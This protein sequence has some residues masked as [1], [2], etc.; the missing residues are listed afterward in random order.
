MVQV[1]EQAKDFNALL[2]ESKTDIEI[3]QDIEKD[4]NA[5]NQS[6]TSE[7]KQSKDNSSNQQ[8]FDVTFSAEDKN[9][10]TVN[11]AQQQNRENTKLIMQNQKRQDRTSLT[12]LIERNDSSEEG[13]TQKSQFKAKTQ[14]LNRNLFESEI[15]VVEQ[16]DVK[17]SLVYNMKASIISQNSEYKRKR[18][19]FTSSVLS[20]GNTQAKINQILNMQIPESELKN[21]RIQ[22]EQ[23]L[24]DQNDSQISD[25]S[26]LLHQNIKLKEPI[27]HENSNGDIQK[28]QQKLYQTPWDEVPNQLQ[29]FSLLVRQR[30]SK[31]LFRLKENTDTLIYNKNNLRVYQS[32]DTETLFSIKGL[33]TIFKNIINTPQTIILKSFYHIDADVK[34][35][36]LAQQNIANY[37][38]WDQTVV[39]TDLISILSSQF[40]Q[41]YTQTTQS[42]LGQKTAQNMKQNALQNHSQQRLVSHIRQLDDKRFFMIQ[43]SLLNC[44]ITDESL[45]RKGQK[46]YWVQM[47]AKEKSKLK[48]NNLGNDQAAQTS[49]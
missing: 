18:K 33:D 34:A 30:Q 13:M 48:L 11:K 8:V 37:Q 36:K 3:D 32:T 9:R 47:Q 1:V 43:Q 41:M 45:R 22:N 14:D 7:Q 19:Q 5:L 6:Q 31:T 29:P 20:I 40:S 28:L 46:L 23:L 42:I 25:E 27:Q 16:P 49:L 35:V 21:A 44:Q 39:Q 10:P 15:M 24:V 12:P 17:S 4:I 38:E 26:K 2:D